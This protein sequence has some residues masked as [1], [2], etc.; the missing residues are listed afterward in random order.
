MAA[1]YERAGPLNRALR[2]S[3]PYGNKVLWTIL[4]LV[5]CDINAVVEFRVEMQEVP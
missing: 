3:H 1:K 4:P 5:D 2:K